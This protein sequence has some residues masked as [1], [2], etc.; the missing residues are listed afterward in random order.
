MAA[1]RQVDALR[2]P[3]G[4]PTLG[5]EYGKP[6][7]LPFFIFVTK[8]RIDKQKK[9]LLSSHM[10][11]TCAYNMVTFGPLTAAICWRVWGTPANFNGFRVLVP[12]LNGTLVVGVCQT[13]QR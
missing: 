11:S 8:A 9:N 4:S 1:Y 12:L 2:S 3:A 10:S 6:L 5:I 7:P 13:L